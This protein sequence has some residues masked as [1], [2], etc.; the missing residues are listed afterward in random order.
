MNTHNF[1]DPFGKFIVDIDVGGT[2]TDAII[3]RRNRVEFFKVDTTPDDLSQCIEEVFVRAVTTLEA[4]DIRSL[5]NQVQIIRLST[6]L[7]LNTLVERKGARLGLLLS[8][9]WRT[10]F[11]RQPLSIDGSKPLILSDMVLDIDDFQNALSHGC[12]RISED[13]VRDKSR[14][15]LERGAT[16]LVLSFVGAEYSP[17]SESYVKGITHKYFPRHFIG[18]VPVMLGSQVSS[19][20][21]YIVRTNTALL[22]A[23]CHGA[24]ANKLFQI[25]EFLRGHGGPV[26]F[27]AVHSSGGISRAAKT[28]PIHTISSG[29]AASMFG[30]EGLARRYGRP[31]I[32]SLDIG[33]TSTEIGHIHSA[34]IKYDGQAEVEGLAVDLSNP[35]ARYLGLG[36][37]SI[38]WFDGEGEIRIG[39]ES[40]GSFPGPACYDNGGTAPTLTDVYLVLGYL[41]EGYFLGGLK[42][43]KKDVAR[44]AFSEKIAR[45]LGITCEQAA[46]MAKMKAVG[47][48]GNEILGL[49]SGVKKA[50]SAYCLFA[51][52]GGGGCIGADVAECI[53]TGKTYIFRQGAVFGAFGSSSMD[54]AHT[55]ERK[56]N[57]PVFG[58][59]VSREE[60]CRTLNNAVLSLQRT[61]FKD[62]LGEGFRSEEIRFEI[63][64]ELNAGNSN[65]PVKILL[66][67]PF[68]WPAR[69]WP[70]LRSKAAEHLKG[71]GSDKTELALMITKIVI[72]ALADVPHCR[73]EYSP[74]SGSAKEFLKGRRLI[75]VG[76]NAFL[77]ADVYEWDLL[78]V[79]T[80][81]SGPALI[82]S[83][84][85]TIVVP[86]DR[87]IQFDKNYNGVII[88]AEKGDGNEGKNHR[89]P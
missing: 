58:P 54:I 86:P 23:Y 83:P 47:V 35:V 12:P 57:V 55:Y 30:A 19:H 60:I 65:R 80:A 34:A 15:L 11:L 9:G 88:R 49:I 24:I 16:I 27:L 42:R 31:E 33:G 36:G 46:F 53:G 63:E 64:A 87:M 66:P 44:R 38:V 17:D 73:L 67:T 21:D 62:M 20:S 5:L 56:V 82:E 72:R 14:I 40:T 50:P 81:I 79:P 89:V 6:S 74:R 4:G 52:G 70:V 2:F 45:P 77:E 25:E 13:E 43:I 41:D 32:I 22:N 84:D 39:P 18:S 76:K 28:R 59:G 85:T 51:T 8:K 3:S 26:P 37:G 61:A 7:T 29:A 68:I 48:I 10:R 75:Y 1:E 69:D 71:Q 78:P